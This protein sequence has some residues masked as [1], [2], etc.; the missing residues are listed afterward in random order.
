MRNKFMFFLSAGLIAVLAA[1]PA[2]ARGGQGPEN[3]KVAQLIHLMDKDKNGVVSKDEFMR[4]M[5]AEFDRVDANRSG[6]LSESELSRS[7]LARRNGR[8]E[9][10]TVKGLIRQMDR[11]Q[12]G[13]VEKDE[14]LAFVSEEF[15][16]LDVDRS[17]TLTGGELSNS[18]FVHPQAK[19]PGGTHK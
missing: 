6:A 12:T 7:V 9:L 4:F 10:A 8:A 15:D 2:L 18:V 19:H 1:A 5:S 3:A 16:R 11:N 14:F 17:G 13:E